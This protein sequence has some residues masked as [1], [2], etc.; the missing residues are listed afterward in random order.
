VLVFQHAKGDSGLIFILPIFMYLFVVALGTD[1]NILMIS[2]LREEARQG[3]TPREAA[4]IAL[5]HAGPTVGSAGLILSGTFV[6]FI[7][8]GGSTLA[9]LGFAISLGIAVAAF[10]MALFLT[11]AITALIGHAAW[12]PGHQDEAREH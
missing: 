8:A 5:Q 6:S 2:R 1:Y 4:A 7:F 10:V 3:K 9:P 11:P 12:W